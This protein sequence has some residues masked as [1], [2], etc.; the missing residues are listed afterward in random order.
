MAYSSIS[1]NNIPYEGLC[2]GIQVIVITMDKK[3]INIEILS[4]THIKKK[5]CYAR[6][7]KP[8]LWSY[9]QGLQRNS[10]YTP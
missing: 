7:S 8:R 10:G 9:S 3:V 1:L 6:V 2:N 4:G 5:S